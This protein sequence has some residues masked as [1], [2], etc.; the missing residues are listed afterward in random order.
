MLQD[1]DGRSQEIVAIDLGMSRTNYNSILSGRS[2][3][4]VQV[5]IQLADYFNVS[6]DWLCGRDDFC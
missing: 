5:L 3:P 1:R 2:L 4:S 6:L